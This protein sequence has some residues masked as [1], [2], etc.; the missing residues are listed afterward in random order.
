[1]GKEATANRL[2][3]DGRDR[4]PLSGDPATTTL[5]ISLPAP[6]SLGGSRSWSWQ[7]RCP[8]P[9]CS[10]SSA[11]KRRKR[12]RCVATCRLAKT[13]G[14]PHLRLRLTSP[15]LF[16]DLQ[17][18]FLT[19]AERAALALEKRQKEIEEQKAVGDRAR[20]ER[21]ALDRKL[22]EERRAA[23]NAPAQQYG[24]SLQASYNPGGPNVRG[25]R[26]RGAHGGGRGGRGGYNDGNGRGGY[27]D[28][29]S[30]VTVPVIVRHQSLAVLTSVP[31]VPRPLAARRSVLPSRRSPAQRPV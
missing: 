20:M 17:P 10:R 12:P 15:D 29:A 23:Y 16:P 18:K 25:G 8:L 5:E 7:D 3:E 1:M 22:D 21:E 26:G 14:S 24:G 4:P 31:V 27:H 19:K 28:G 13:E 2:L 6:L 9:T 11:R 30:P